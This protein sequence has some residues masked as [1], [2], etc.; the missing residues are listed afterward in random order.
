MRH[1]WRTPGARRWSCRDRPR[2]RWRLLAHPESVHD[3][4]HA[5]Q[6][7][8]R[9]RLSHDSSRRVRTRTHQRPHQDLK[10][11]EEPAELLR[12]SIDIQHRMVRIRREEQREAGCANFEMCVV[13]RVRA[14]DVERG[15]STLMFG[16]CSPWLRKYVRPD[17]PDLS[18]MERGAPE[19]RQNARLMTVRA[20]A[21]RAAP[22][23]LTF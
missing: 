2:R 10:L 5:D 7:G 9:R 12:R 17:D 8:A 20:L 13:V 4:V 19:P 11:S 1:V 6:P 15:R 21:R 18:R 16:I 3:R 14:G 22:L 23:A